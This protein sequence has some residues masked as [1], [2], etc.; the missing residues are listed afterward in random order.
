MARGAR[1]SAWPCGRCQCH[2]PFAKDEFLTNFAKL[3]GTFPSNAQVVLNSG[4]ADANAADPAAPL[5]GGGS[6]N[7]LGATP[8]R[9]R[10]AHP[11]HTGR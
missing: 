10:C 3:K 11:A 6:I 8:A 4:A 7:P 5:R 9:D 2:L 1:S